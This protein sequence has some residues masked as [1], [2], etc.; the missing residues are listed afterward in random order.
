MIV[1]SAAELQTELVKI[2][3]E[4][5]PALFAG[6]GVSS[7][8]NVPVWG[9]YLLKLAHVAE[10]FE[11]LTAQLMRKRI[12]AGLFPEAAHFYKI[13]TEIPA[14]EKSREL[15]APFAEDKIDSYQLDQLCSLPFRNVVTTN[16]DRALHSAFARTLNLS[17]KAAEL[18]DPTLR[19]SLFWNDF[20]IARI[21]GRA[22]VPHSIV[23]DTD[24][25]R[26]LD[27]NT[28]YLDLLRNALISQTLLFVGFSFL[29]PA[30]SQVLSSIA[31][32]GVQPSLHYA[33][34]PTG[35]AGL[36]AR[37]ASFNIKII[38]YDPR[39]KHS[40]LW[41]GIALA[42]E[43]LRRGNGT[44]AVEP[45]R[46][47]E[48]AK[49]LL[50]TCYARACMGRDVEALKYLVV[51]GIILSE[52]DKGV[53]S[54]LQL[55]ERLRSYM[56]LTE[57]EAATMIDT[58]VDRLVAKGICMR[59]GDAV[60][61]VNSVPLDR[62]PVE[63]L[64]AGVVDRAHVREKFTVT[65]SLRSALT[66]VIEE[67]IVLRG[68]DLGA[69][70][71]GAHIDDEPDTSST[72][73][74]SIERHLPNEWQDKKRLLGEV[75][76][77]LLRHPTHKE[78]T[79]LGE[80]GRLAFGIELLLQSGR[81]AVYGF[82]L[83]HV[84]YL[85]S[86]VLMPAIVPG[87][88]NRR[89]Y[90]SAIKR[91]QDAAGQ[92]GGGFA[93]HIADVILDEIVSHRRKAIDMVR[94]GDLD[95]VKVLERRILYYGAGNVNVYI[96]GFGGWIKDPQNKGKQFA[97]FLNAEAPYNTEKE[98]RDYISKM[99]ITAVSTSCAES[100]QI[101]DKAEIVDLLFEGYEMQ[102][103]GLSYDDRKFDVLKRHEAAQLYLLKQDIDAG[104]R[105]IFVTADGRLRKAVADSPLARFRDALM[106]PQNLIQLVDLVI[107]MDVPPACLSRLLWSVKIADDKA[108]IKDY[109]VHRAMPHYDAALLLKVSDVLDNYADKVL[110]EAKLENIDLKP[111]K[112]EDRLA[113]S[114][115]MDRVEDG[116]FSD[117]AQQVRTLKTQMKEAGIA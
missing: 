46:N 38:E 111:F 19:Q 108:L 55:Q 13:C 33:L 39:D 44:S 48:T 57:Q 36:S 94:D 27:T 89:A 15:I 93:V 21:H 61:L 71:S 23:L 29:D 117:L 52:M 63:V 109:L 95:D 67:V 26:A 116:L 16:Y 9:E 59:D 8:A 70:F 91:L 24:D 96:S 77:D 22:E 112:F 60:V 41:G 103:R 87:H 92:S 90:G 100:K 18:N 12:E 42:N 73:S 82:T 25:Y 75:F 4:Q 58:N 74:A 98:L 99:G 10:E 110:R 20:Y 72:F 5:K 84:I 114:R 113:T 88:P 76:E 102:E 51:E 28:D 107:G 62:S 56:A 1:G 53:Q 45:T 66:S 79:V 64:V 101:N 43:E 37:L 31:K 7:R 78:E 115:F 68:F 47:F 6:A 104:R 54:L 81:A 32:T 30:I 11:P 106:S 105:P 50:A 83:P 35:Q 80:L 34:I 85:D 86:N 17:P 97:D 3:H 49:R 40:L 2:F 14:G 69:E 65:E